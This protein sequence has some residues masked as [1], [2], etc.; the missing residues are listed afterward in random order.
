MA[1]KNDL[2]TVIIMALFSLGY[3]CETTAIKVFGGMGKS[4]IDS[5]TVPRVWGGCLLFLSIALIIRS[6]RGKKKHSGEAKG[7]KEFI[8][9]KREVIETF[10][11]LTFYI[12][13][14][15]DV[16][17]VISSLIYIF[18]QTI[19]LS[20]PGEKHYKLAGGLALVF[21]I[22]I[23]YVFVEWLMVLLPAG[24]LDF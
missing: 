7:W 13:I 14:M 6:L 24:L 8:N 21:A 18:L 9:E 10:V 17:F 19:I 2:I 12:A 22:G 3:L 11:L 16:G 15:E 23:Y 20:P 4:V 5:G 1:K